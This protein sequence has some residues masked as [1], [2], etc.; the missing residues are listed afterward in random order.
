MTVADRLKLA[1]KKHAPEAF[2]GD[3]K[4]FQ[5]LMR[6]RMGDRGGGTSYPAVLGYFAGRTS[7]SVEWLE[8]AADVLGV[9]AAWLAFGEGAETDEREVERVRRNHARDPEQV[10]RT[11][12]AVLTAFYA[13]CGGLRPIGVFAMDRIVL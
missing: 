2:G 10:Q 5:R 12:S 7:P 13:N 11:I 8:N 9:R 6:E 1:L 4:A 3:R